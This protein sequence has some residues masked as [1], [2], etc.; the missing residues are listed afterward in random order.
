MI[1]IEEIPVKNIE[2][3]WRIH[4]AYLLND[5]II[6]EE[7]DKEYFQSEEY[8]GVIKFHMLREVDKHHMVYFVENEKRI[9]AAQYNTYQSEDGKC[10]ILDFW[11]FPEYRGDGTGHRCFAALES[12]TRADGAKYY[13]INCERENAQ[14][15][16]RDNGFVDNGVD[17]YEMALMVKG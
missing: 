4:Y 14:R 10:F 16:W 7:E 11:V 9:G 5:E 13:V 17:E 1:M 3:F 8:R 6:T 2:D 15:F 12:Y